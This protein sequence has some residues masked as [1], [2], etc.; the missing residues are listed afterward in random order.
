MKKRFILAA[1]LAAA[2][3][4][5]FAEDNGFSYTYV[6]GGYT[7]ARV[8]NDDELLGDFDAKGAYLRGSF[9]VSPSFYFFGGFSR[10]KDD[11]SVTFDLGDEQIRVDVEDEL[12]LAEGGVG[13]HMAMGERVDF[14]A[15]L[16]YLRLEEEV[17]VSAEGESE[18]ESFDNNAGRIA[19][20]LRGGSERMEGWVKAGYIDGSDFSGEFVG[21][22]GGQYKFNQTW[23][24]VG[25]V[26][27]FNDLTRFNAGVRASF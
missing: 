19:V 2:P 22:L 8:D 1:M 15:E 13:Y 10:A 17:K 21:T 23:G 11:D 27:V 16:S 26:E 4:A 5:A 12:T 24:L 20:G 7:Q 9:A 14:L 18:K 6:E 25:E 3:F